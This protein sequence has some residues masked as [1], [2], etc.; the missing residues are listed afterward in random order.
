[1]KFFK[2]NTQKCYVKR[3]RKEGRA[4]RWEGWKEGRKERKGGDIEGDLEILW[5]NETSL[6][7]KI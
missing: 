5:S 6:E 7:T 1:M 3:R 2:H 4:G